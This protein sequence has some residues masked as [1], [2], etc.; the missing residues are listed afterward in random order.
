MRA[1]LAGL[2]NERGQRPH[3]PSGDARPLHTFSDAFVPDMVSALFVEAISWWLE[4]GRP[5]TPKEIA[6]RSARLAA[7][8]FKEAS[9]W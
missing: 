4:Q 1:A 8:L 6:M 2:L 3:G 7:T 9:A 5:Y